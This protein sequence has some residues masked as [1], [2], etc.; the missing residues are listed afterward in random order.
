[1]NNFK[2]YLIG[3]FG[4][5][6]GALVVAVVASF[7]AA[8][9]THQKVNLSEND[10]IPAM[11]EKQLM[12]SVAVSEKELAASLS[13]YE[14]R[15]QARDAEYKQ[16]LEAVNKAE[17]ALSQKKQEISKRELE[18]KKV[19]KNLAEMREQA[20]RL[21]AQQ[22]QAAAEDKKKRAEELSKQAEL[23]KKKEAEKQRLDEERKQEEEVKRRLA[24]Q[25][26]ANERALRE[27]AERNRIA[28]ERELALIRGKYEDDIHN[29]LYDAWMLPYDRE[30]VHCAVALSLAP[31]GTILDFKFRTACPSDYKHMI[32]LAIQRVNKLPRVPEKIFK[33]VEVVNFIDVI[34]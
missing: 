10:A 2:K 9:P 12:E 30:N 33:P 11:T 20:R 15:S 31:D 6:I 29:L 27:I 17:K 25:K 23:R 22:E 7:V 28:E 8:T 5:H 18:L 34:K 3:S 32:D 14:K 26:Q 4:F 13:Q 1:M 24:A 16:K 19:N 21:K